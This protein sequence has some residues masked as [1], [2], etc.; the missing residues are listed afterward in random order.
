MYNYPLC[1]TQR[2]KK[3]SEG[4]EMAFF[5]SETYQCSHVAGVAQEKI[6]SY[7]STNDSEA[8][9]QNFPIIEK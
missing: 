9:N 2:S 4:S 8:L 7:R 1:Y 5:V 3:I 6:P